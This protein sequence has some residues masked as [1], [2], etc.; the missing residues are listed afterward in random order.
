MTTHRRCDD[1]E[2]FDPA[3]LRVAARPQNG[4]VSKQW[5][6]GTMTAIILAGGA[7]WATYMQSEVQAISEEQR[8]QK[9]GAGDTKRETAVIKEKVDRLEQDMK[10]V[11]GEQKDQSKKLDELLRRV[12]P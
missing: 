3:P 10:E 1:P 2:V 8:K 6:I 11:R 7:G 5:L 4:S 12:R 9:D